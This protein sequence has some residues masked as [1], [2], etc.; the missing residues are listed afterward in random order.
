MTPLLFGGILIF[1]VLVVYV[2]ISTYRRERQNIMNYSQAMMTSLVQ[3]LEIKVSSVESA[4]VTEGHKY[5][6]LPARKKEI[7]DNL[8]RL[9]QDNAFIHN[10]AL[11]TWDEYEDYNPEAVSVT[12]YAANDSLAGIITGQKA[13]RN[14]DV[15]AE[16]M[17]C[18][19]K[20]HDTGLPC[21]SQPYFDEKF[22]NLYIVT[23]YHR[24]DG[25]GLML[26]A[27]VEVSRL[28]HDIDTL[29]F[30][31]NSRLYISDAAGLTYTLEKSDD[32]PAPEMLD[33]INE[34][35]FENKDWIA[36]S[37]HFDK[38][39]IDIV[40]LV[41]K[42]EIDNVLWR[43]SLVALA[44]FLFGLAILAG[45]VHYKFK[46][47][48]ED[49]ERSLKKSAKE[50]MALKQIESEIGI[51]ARIQMDMLSSPGKGVHLVPEEGLPADLM[52]LLITAKEVGGDLYEYR[53]DGHNL[54]LCIADVS[55]KGIPASVVMTKC[56]T[57]FHAYASAND[58]PDPADMLLYM[59]S[60]LSRR[61]ENLMFAT[62]WT[63]VL[64]LRTGRLRYASAAH[65]PPVLLSDR[66]TLLACDNG[67]PLGLFDDAT[68][69]T[70]ECTL[71]KGDALLLYTDGITEA[72]G[73]G[74]VLFGEERLLEACGSAVSRNPQV[75]CDTV[76]RAVR[77]HT[78]GCTQ[79]DDITLL[80]V[81][82]GGRFAQ[83][84]DIDEVKA[85]HTLSQECG[86]SYRTALAL[87]E[88]SV[89]VFDHGGG[90]FVSAECRDG[91]FTLVDDGAE[92]DPT[93]Y[94]APADDEELSI[95]G[96]GIALVKSICPV[97]EYSRSRDYNI[98][99][100]KVQE[101]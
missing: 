17:L 39:G 59:N 25:D 84:R 74:D 44:I 87:E 73:P 31:N 27:D 49:L 45:A 30:Y 96:N 12:Y 19:S 5:P 16:E 58:D 57:L 9:V 47:A 2:S 28:L 48:Q 67:T 63:G 88:L 70:R 80:C 61:N 71:G 94:E 101:L 21:W 90:T 86:G 60:Q 13:V 50:E 10:A 4:L 75:V 81:S 32:F 76:M 29:Q 42:D 83:V 35:G 36:I 89:N 26:S 52:S 53:L 77:A 100:L 65:N 97:F 54:V 34:S 18:Y 33:E 78:A 24:C 38:L 43:R 20:A 23:C 91:T 41:P 64:D 8:E 55:G 6:S 66:A 46:K 1:A 72:E 82:W 79:S 62:M 99:T 15:S 51:A 98:T 92:F 95:G 68:F 11:D 69:S 14:G 22:T 85:L 40:N 93:A 7:Y 56:C 37:R 3:S